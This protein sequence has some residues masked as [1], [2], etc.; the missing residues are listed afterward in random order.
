MPRAVP[1]KY[2]DCSICRL[3]PEGRGLEQQQTVSNHEKADRRR[4][5]RAARE[6]PN[7]IG[8]EFPEGD[9][10]AVRNDVGLGVAPGDELGDI[11]EDYGHDPYH[12]HLDSDLSYEPA[13]FSLSEDSEIEHLMPHFDEPQFSDS[14]E[15]PERSKDEQDLLDD[16]L[17]RGR[18]LIF[19]EEDESRGEDME[20]DEE[21]P[22]DL[23]P[24]FQEHPAIRNAYIRAF[25]L[26]SL[27]GATH[28]AVQ[29]H[30]EGVAVGLRSAMAQS[31]D[32]E[33][34]GLDTM[35]RT[36]A[37]AERRL[38][39]STDQF[40]TYFFLCNVCWAIHHPS[41]LADLAEPICGKDGCS[42]C[43]Y[44][45]KRLSSGVIKRTPT[46]ILPYV[47]PKKAIQHLLLRPGKYEQLQE[48]RGPGDEP[49]QVAPLTVMGHDAF[50][51]PSKPM[52]DVY[53]G[54]GWR[55]IQAGLERQR[56]GA[57]TIRDVDVHALHQ[58]F[59]SLPLGLVWQMNID[60]WV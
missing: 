51:D 4:D 54:W 30:L 55:A 45:V 7:A 46:K 20:D 22:D 17:F 35:A 47:R 58:R 8:A 33:F 32:V 1:Y 5:E 50:P 12:Y 36:L 11:F 39:I 3:K 6:D 34:A 53:D 42:G 49:G 10:M 23:P 27:K 37:T 52:R 16:P 19:G 44:T 59:V 57:W 2:C 38:G 21:D 14:D 29:I 56:G 24:A 26:A 60:W 41:E 18:G 9:H 31:T 40:I 28:A 15:E 48:W 25:L 43:L 13:D